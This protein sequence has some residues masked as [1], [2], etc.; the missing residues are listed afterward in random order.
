MTKNTSDK[1]YSEITYIAKNVEPSRF[2]TNKEL[3]KI[4]NLTN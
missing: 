3:E 2:M 1:V 4:I